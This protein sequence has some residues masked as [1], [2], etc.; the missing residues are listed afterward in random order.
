VFYRSSYS[1]FQVKT[2]F[3][4]SVPAAAVAT[5]TVPADCLLWR[6]HKFRRVILRNGNASIRRLSLRFDVTYILWGFLNEIQAWLDVKIVI[7]DL[8]PCNLAEIS[9]R[10]DRCTCRETKN[11]AVDCCFLIVLRNSAQKTRNEMR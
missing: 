4:I 6:K 10:L 9:G 3:F 2:I 5:G 7:C 11:F 1:K 8:T